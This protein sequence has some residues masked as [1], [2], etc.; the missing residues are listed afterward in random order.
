MISYQRKLAHRL[1]VPYAEMGV[2]SWGWMEFVEVVGPRQDL[3]DNQMY[4]EFLKDKRRRKIIEMQTLLKK[5]YTR[6]FSI[7]LKGN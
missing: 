5:H 6:E 4:I 7:T 2:V 3:D 1:R